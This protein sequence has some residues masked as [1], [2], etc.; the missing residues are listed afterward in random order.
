MSPMSVR[1]KDRSSRRLAPAPVQG[2]PF[3]ARSPDRGTEHSARM[4]ALR[5]FS[6][7]LVHSDAAGRHG[8][9]RVARPG[10]SVETLGSWSTRWIRNIHDKVLGDRFASSAYHRLQHCRHRGRPGNGDRVRS[11]Q[12]LGLGFRDFTRLAASDRLCGATSACT[13]R[14]RSW[15]CS[16]AS[17]RISPPCNARSAGA[18]ATSSSIS[19]PARGRYAARSFRPVRT[20]PC[21]IRP[22]RDGSEVG[23]K[24]AAKTVAHRAG[25]NR[26]ERRRGKAVP[27]R[28]FSLTVASFLAAGKRLQHVGDVVDQVGFVRS[29][30]HEVFPARRRYSQA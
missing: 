29:D 23:W 4:P 5:A 10:C 20:P 2:R 15:K 1:P 18:T 11:D 9:R 3:R 24:S 30:L 16:P 22:A 14:T 21:P 19:S 28:T 8:R 27:S 6:A 7:A 17:P 25:S 12:I 13:T 26:S